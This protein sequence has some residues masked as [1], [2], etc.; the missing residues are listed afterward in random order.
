[1]IFGSATVVIN[2]RNFGS[3]TTGVTVMLNGQPVSVRNIQS[4]N[5]RQIRFT[6]PFSVPDNTSRASAMSGQLIAVDVVVQANT[7][8]QCQSNTLSGVFAS[9]SRLASS[10]SQFVSMFNTSPASTSSDTDSE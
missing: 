9:S 7:G 5:D 2:G 10:V 3:S 4:I 8:S 1:M 6:A